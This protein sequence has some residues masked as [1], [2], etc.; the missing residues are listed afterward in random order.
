MKETAI[1]NERLRPDVVR[2]RKRWRSLQAWIDPDRLVFI[3]ETCVKTNMSPLRGWS[4][5]GMRLNGHTPHRQWRTSTFL[6]GLRRHAI[7]DPS[8][9]KVR[10]T[11]RSSR[12]MS[13]TSSCDPAAGRHRHQGQSWQPQRTRHPDTGT[14]GRRKGVVLAALQPRPQPDRAGRRQAEASAAKDSGTHD[15]ARLGP[16]RPAAKRFSPEECANYVAN[17]GYRFNKN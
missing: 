4:A 3:D 11:A 12:P 5:R 17:S 10:S 15:R 8:S 16:H 2:R 7:I 14:R 1:A 9:S 6:A 13:L